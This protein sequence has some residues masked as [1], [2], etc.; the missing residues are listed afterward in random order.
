MNIHEENIGQ[1]WGTRRSKV[2]RRKSK[3]PIDYVCDATFK[4]IRPNW[5]NLT[6]V[7]AIIVYEGEVL[8]DAVR[9]RD[10][11]WC[12]DHPFDR[13]ACTQARKLIRVQP[14]ENALLENDGIITLTAK[15]VG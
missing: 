7:L 15:G 11:S 8:I 2:I 13:Q 14:Y 10:A 1:Y 5:G 9:R 12:K 6:Q 4:I 3:V